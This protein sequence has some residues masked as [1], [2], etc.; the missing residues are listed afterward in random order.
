MSEEAL[1][2]GLSGLGKSM[3]KGIIEHA[4]AIG[5]ELP[6]EL[7]DPDAQITP[8]QILEVL[9]GVACHYFPLLTPDFTQGSPRSAN[10]SGASGTSQQPHLQAVS[11]L[12]LT[13][14]E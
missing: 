3:G 11:L 10:K 6:P 2:K 7:N 13:L 12:V 4:R 14:R 1:A 9:R 8:D 5:V